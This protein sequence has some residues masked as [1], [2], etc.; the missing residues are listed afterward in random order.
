MLAKL[1]HSIIICQFWLG[2]GERPTRHG[3]VNMPCIYNEEKTFCSKICSVFH[4]DSRIQ[5]K[6]LSEE[7]CYTRN[8]SFH[9]TFSKMFVKI[10]HLP[11]MFACVNESSY[12]NP[13][14]HGTVNMSCIYNE[15]KTF[16]SNICLVCHLDPL[17]VHDLA[18]Q[19]PDYH[20]HLSFRWTMMSNI[21]WVLQ[22][23]TDKTWNSSTCLVSTMKKNDLMGIL[24]NVTLV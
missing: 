13:T 20:L 9:W 10:H 5:Q 2:A 17:L 1:H 7:S 4:L 22:H 19:C 8:Q 18:S 16:C 15:E 3:T 12:I 24:Y 21:G 23:P 6:Y 14:G 11:F